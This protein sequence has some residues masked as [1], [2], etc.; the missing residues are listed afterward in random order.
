[1]KP[2][3]LKALKGSIRKWER[4]VAGT[5]ADNGWENCPLCKLHLDKDCNGCPVK[6]ATGK[7]CCWDTPYSDDWAKSVR[8]GRS[9]WGFANTL[10]RKAAARKELAF[11]KRLL[12]K[13]TKRKVV[14]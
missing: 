4:I 14:S 7:A 2:A 9:C 11:L 13:P 3:T 10:A 12:P 6:A 8:R 5:G 1:M